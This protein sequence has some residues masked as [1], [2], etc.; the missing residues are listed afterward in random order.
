LTAFKQKSIVD[1]TQYRRGKSFIHWPVPKVIVR[2]KKP[3]DAHLAALRLLF[4][5]HQ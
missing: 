3:V 2:K 4:L 1:I 5:L